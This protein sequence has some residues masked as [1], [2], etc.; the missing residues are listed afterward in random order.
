MAE[1]SRSISNALI[2]LVIK[3]DI[4]RRHEFYMESTCIINHGHRPTMIN[5]EE[6]RGITVGTP[7]LLVHF[8]RVYIEDKRKTH[9]RKR[10]G[11]LLEN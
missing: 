11:A 2:P 9:N 3:I 1:N 6:L 5:I 10:H 4:Q 8:K 7:S